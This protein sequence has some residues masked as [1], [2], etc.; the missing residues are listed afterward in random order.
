MRII[1]LHELTCDNHVENFIRAVE[2]PNCDLQQRIYETG[3]SMANILKNTNN[4]ELKNTIMD[5]FNFYN[6]GIYV[7]NYDNKQDVAIDLL[8]IPDRVCKKIISISKK[9]DKNKAQSFV[10]KAAKNKVRFKIATKVFLLRLE[11]ISKSKIR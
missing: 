5:I 4:S 2:A 3:E 6:C 9:I 11:E 8:D 7:C 10:D 1:E